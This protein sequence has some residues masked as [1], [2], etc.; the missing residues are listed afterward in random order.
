MYECVPNKRII[1]D[2]RFK[3]FWYIIAFWTGGSILGCNWDKN[4]WRLSLHA[5]HCHL[6]QLI[7]L[8]P[9][10]GFL[11]PEIS[12]PTAESR[13][14]LCF[15]YIISLFTFQNSIVLSLI[16]LYLYVYKCLFP[17]KTI[18]INASKEGKPY[19]KPYPIP[20]CFRNL[21]KELNQRRKLKFVRE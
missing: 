21:Y 12:T 5:I 6:H 19:R 3:I 1:R 10:H 11:G 14:G 9:S 16:T 7:L 18:S 4:I 2:L 15:V 8:P 20:N 17:I 13:L